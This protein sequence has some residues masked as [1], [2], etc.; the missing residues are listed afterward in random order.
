MN[1]YASIF[2]KQNGNLYVQITCSLTQQTERI[3]I[4][5]QFESS[6]SEFKDSNAK[7]IEQKP[8]T[9][10]LF[11]WIFDLTPNQFTSIAVLFTLAFITILN[12]LRS[13]PLS[14]R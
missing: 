10:D 4:R 9:S 8:C 14:E 7:N 12:L 5:F 3:P 13:R 1:S 2:Q 11:G 6:N